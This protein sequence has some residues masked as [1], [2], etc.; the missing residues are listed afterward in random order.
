VTSHI[1][2]VIASTK[3]WSISQEQLRCVPKQLSKRGIAHLDRKP[4]P[5]YAMTLSVCFVSMPTTTFGRGYTY[6]YD[7]RF[8][9]ILLLFSPDI[10]AVKRE[11]KTLLY[12]TRK[13]LLKAKVRASWS[14]WSEYIG[15]VSRVKK[16]V[17]A[18][19]QHAEASHAF[20]TRGHHCRE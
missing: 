6:C 2:E 1:G 16:P 10:D 8:E 20:P 13:P 7:T 3:S 18:S 12:C 15:M 4:A 17:T 11:K 9:I 5:F 19:I 14:T